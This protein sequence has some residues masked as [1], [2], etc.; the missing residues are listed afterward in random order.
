[1]RISS[2]NKYDILLDPQ[3]FL[4]NVNDQGL[5]AG[6]IVVKVMQISYIT[7]TH[8]NV[9]IHIGMYRCVYISLSVCVQIQHM[10]MCTSVY[11]CGYVN[12]DTEISNCIEY[13]KMYVNVSISPTKKYQ[14]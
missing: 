7:P 5:S 10:H 12:T 11:V 8:A 2:E 1:M 13:F 3:I 9:L 4:L 6:G 14:L